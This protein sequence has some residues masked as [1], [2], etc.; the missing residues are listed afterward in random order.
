MFCKKCG[1]E[2]EETVGYCPNCGYKLVKEEAIKVS[3]NGRYIDE[4]GFLRKPRDKGSGISAWI[5]ASIIFAIA[6]RLPSEYDLFAIIL[7]LIG[8]YSVYFAIK[9]YSS[10]DIETWKHSTHIKL[11]IF[12]GSLFGLGGIIVYY[13]LKGKELKYLTK[14]NNQS[15]NVS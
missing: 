9:I 4:E 13:Y 1:K 14:M 12:V 3:E 7:I 15:F 5:V 10:H 6:N 2:L 11:W 8:A